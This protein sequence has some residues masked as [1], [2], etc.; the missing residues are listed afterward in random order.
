MQTYIESPLGFLL[1]LNVLLLA[2]GA[3]LDIFSAIVIM[4]PLLLPVAAF[5]AFTRYI[6]YRISG[7]YADRLLYSAGG[8][9][10]VYRQLSLQ[11]AVARALCGSMAVPGG[12]ASGIAADYLFARVEFVAPRLAV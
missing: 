10:S 12:A 4:V 2:L 5:M 6:R 1:L 9:E 11:Q 8:H 7:E 3:V